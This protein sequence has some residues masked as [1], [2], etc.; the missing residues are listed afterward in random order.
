MPCA[1]TLQIAIEFDVLTGGFLC[2]ADYV[3]SDNPNTYESY[4][5][6]RTERR[7]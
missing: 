2:V 4:W 6:R 7:G 1:A 3:L 5:R